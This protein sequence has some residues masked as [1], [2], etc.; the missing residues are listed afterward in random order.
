MIPISSRT[1]LDH[2][3]NISYRATASE[4]NL[5]IVVVSISVFLCFILLKNSRN[6]VEFKLL[7]LLLL[8]SLAN[9]LSVILNH[10][11]GIPLLFKFIFY[12][13]LISHSL[14][15]LLLI[16]TAFFDNFRLK[17]NH[18]VVYVSYFLLNLILMTV[19]HFIQPL[20]E[21]QLLRFIYIS[22]G[23]VLVILPLIIEVYCL[24]IIIKE[25]KADLIEKRRKLRL[26]IF[27][28]ILAFWITSVF[29]E[30]LYHR[31]TYAMHFQSIAHICLLFIIGY[32]LI[33]TDDDFFEP[34]HAKLVHKS[35][36]DSEITDH[37]FSKKLDTLMNED[38][39]YCHE[40]ISIGKLAKEMKTQEYLLRAFINQ[41][42]G[43]RN[44]NDFINQ[45]RIEA[46]KK[47]LETT[48]MKMLNISM[49][50][51]IT[52]IASFNRIF[53][54]LT[55]LTPSEYRNLNSKPNFQ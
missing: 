14:I 10:Y 19:M 40:N 43:Y 48:N 11:F 38:R 44:F 41:K 33:R 31:L 15:F 28:I 55:Q 46:A 39:Y 21:V 30:S 1:F 13:F 23:S 35:I 47:L 9:D 54:N 24:F 50:V 52:S 42:L 2:I 26:I 27:L 3:L 22:T 29:S 45:H 51:G 34:I 36:K 5:R 8:V 4:L 20:K 12:A 32:W 17:L 37:P 53:K 49:E 16:Q 25:W 6:W 7:A 18:L